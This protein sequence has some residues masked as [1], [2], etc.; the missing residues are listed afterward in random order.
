V[1]IKVAAVNPRTHR[2]R[3]IP[4]VMFAS[5][6]LDL[7]VAIRDAGNLAIERDASSNGAATDRNSETAHLRQWVE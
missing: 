2:P 6:I 4:F 7:P 5:P 1:V 3:Q